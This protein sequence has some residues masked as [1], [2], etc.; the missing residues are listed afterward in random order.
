MTPLP[1]VVVLPNDFMDEDT[2]EKGG[3]LIVEQLWLRNSLRNS[4]RKVRKDVPPQMEGETAA[5]CCVCGTP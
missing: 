4:L 1:P 2:D 5:V 3:T